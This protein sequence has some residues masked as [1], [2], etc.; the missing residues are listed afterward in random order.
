MS[1]ILKVS[2][3]CSIA[4]HSVVYLA[5]NGKP[6]NVKVLAEAISASENHLSKV[7]QRLVKAGILKSS[8]GPRGG[9]WLVKKPDTITMLDIYETIEGKIEQSQCPLNHDECPFTACLFAGLVTDVTAHVRKYLG[10]R[11]VSDF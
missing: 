10:S 11:K 8:R 3:A 7:L 2:E 5:K 9:F 1:C 4:L 6:L